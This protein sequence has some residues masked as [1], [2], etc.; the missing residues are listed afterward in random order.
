[1]RGIDELH[2]IFG[3]KVISQLGLE[4]MQKLYIL[5]Y[6]ATSLF[7]KNSINEILWD[8]TENCITKLQLEDC[9]IYLLDN[10]EEKLIQ[11]A[12][13][14]NKKNTDRKIAHPI[15][16]PIGKGIVG[17]V[18]G[19]GVPEIVNNTNKD[20]RYILDDLK[21]RSEMAVPIFSDGKVIGVIDSEH[22]EKNFFT[23]NHLH[24][25][26]FIALLL[27]KKITHIIKNRKV[28][29]NDD[30]SY[31]QKFLT[32]LEEKKTYRNQN[33]NLVSAAY[34]LGI[35][36]N[37]LSQL[38]N[39]LSKKNFSEL[40]NEFRIEEVCNHFK[41]PEYAHYSITGIGLESGFQSKSA[42]YKAFKKAK[43]ITPNRYKKSILFN[44]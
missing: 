22:S 18:A 41:N 35:S 44:I 20:T 4:G 14:G 8:V 3:T 23:K 26:Q 21:R 30:N 40:I 16:I 27:E 31:Y 15:I 34:E 12:A 43:G 33:F 29:F 32:L 7:D 36:A 38:V 42:F 19:S 9:V 25:F 10:K 37:Y 1:M 6:F 24:Q 5:N 11:K 39:K 28:I 2:S 17:N 13:H